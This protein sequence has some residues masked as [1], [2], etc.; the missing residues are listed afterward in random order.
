MAYRT[1]KSGRTIPAAG[2]IAVIEL[3]ARV[4]SPIEGL[5]ITATEVPHSTTAFAY[6][7]DAGGHS[8]V[9]SGD[10]TFSK[11]L[12]ELAKDADILVMDSGAIVYQG[13]SPNKGSRRR[14]GGGAYV[15]AH[16]SMESI[17]AMAA[18]ADVKMLVLHHFR[19]G[20]VD[21]EQTRAALAKTYRGTVAFAR[22]MQAFSCAPG[23]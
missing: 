1:R 19:P 7:F 9:I 14:Q 10:L 4:P 2:R 17:A 21:E 11:K 20:R 18:Q 23:R 6:R 22:D 12:I 8:V 3:P 15:P 5:T 16:A 13:E